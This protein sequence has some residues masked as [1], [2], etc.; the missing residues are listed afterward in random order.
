MA[1]F[2]VPV[3]KIERVENHPN[4]DRLSLVYFREYVTIAAKLEDGSHRY[5]VGDLAVYVPEGAVVPEYLLKR[6]FWDEK[7]NKGILAGTRGDRVKAIRL[8]GI[9][10]QGIMFPVLKQYPTF[11]SEY[12]IC[13]VDNGDFDEYSKGPMIR[14]VSEG[15]DVAEFLGIVKYEPPIPT[16]M[17]GEVAY[18]GIGR[19]PHFDVENIK[20]YPDVLVDDEEVVVTEKIHGTC[21]GF[22]FIPGLN[23]PEVWED[24]FVCFSKGLGAKG[25]VFKRNETNLLRNVYVR[26]FEKI[27]PKFKELVAEADRPFFVFGEIYGRGVQDLH[28]GSNEPT[29]R[30][31]EVFQESLNSPDTFLNDWDIVT[32]VANTLNV[33]TVPVLFQG[34]WNKELRQLRDG[35]STLFG[36]IREGIVIKPVVYRRDDVVGNV[37][38][39]DIS[40]AYLTR[41]GEVTEYT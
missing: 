25:L 38:L 14:T 28:Y 32:T 27:F 2:E 30:L 36:H 40:D 33:E 23:N 35:Q 4:A 12:T 9:I 24:N 26:T 20:K 17:A 10:S 7:N 16:A 6:G 37:I 29:V 15:V 1:N 19:V 22:G 5:N 21:F 31:F 41:K 13:V 34:P 11:S 39:K 3:I 8:R 18:I